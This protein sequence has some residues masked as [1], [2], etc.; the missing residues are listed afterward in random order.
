[1]AWL[2]NPIFRLAVLFGVW[3][4]WVGSMM[5]F[6]YDTLFVEGTLTVTDVWNDLLIATFTLYP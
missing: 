6:G 3:T 2:R 1:M 5:Y 4:P